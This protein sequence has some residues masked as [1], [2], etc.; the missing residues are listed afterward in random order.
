L[1]RLVLAAA[2]LLAL[3][4]SAAPPKKRVRKKAAKPAAAKPA[5]PKPAPESPASASAGPPA[6]PAGPV[7]GEIALTDVLRETLSVKTAAG[8]TRE[9]AITPETKFF[10]PARDERGSGL[11]A[12]RVGQPVEIQSPDGRAASEIRVLAAP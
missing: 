1:S 11:D 12:L 6:L 3:G 8:A 10:L 2:A 5:L 4:A 9:Y 7:R